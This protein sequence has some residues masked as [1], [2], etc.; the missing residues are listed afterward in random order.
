MMFPIDRFEAVDIDEEYDFL[1]AETLLFARL[2]K[3]E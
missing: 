2:G 1:L 3:S